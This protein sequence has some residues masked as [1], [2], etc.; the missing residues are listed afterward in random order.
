M[1]CVERELD[2]SQIKNPKMACVEQ[3]LDTSQM[4]IR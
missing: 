3:E 2:T 1:A 4:K